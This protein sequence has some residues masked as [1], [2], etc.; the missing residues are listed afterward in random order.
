MDAACFLLPGCDLSIAHGRKHGGD[1]VGGVASADDSA[2]DFK[3][4]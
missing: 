2:T 3:A 1:E 4:C